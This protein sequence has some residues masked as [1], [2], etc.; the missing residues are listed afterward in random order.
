MILSNE[1]KLGQGRWTPQPPLVGADTAM[2]V[3]VM[4][5]TLLKVAGYLISMNSYP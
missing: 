5:H 3:G 4:Y 1:L 2:K